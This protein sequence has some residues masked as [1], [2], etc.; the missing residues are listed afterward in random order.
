MQTSPCDQVWLRV[1]R[2]RNPRWQL[3]PRP[4]CIVCALRSNGRAFLGRQAGRGA[5]PRCRATPAQ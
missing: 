2:L 3:H 5:G 1:R 4:G